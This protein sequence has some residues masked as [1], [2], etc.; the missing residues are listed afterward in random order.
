MSTDRRIPVAVAGATGSVGQRFVSLLE[1]HPWFRLVEVVASERSAGRPY[2]D[3]VRWAQAGPVPVEAGRLVVRGPEER[4]EAPIVF[5]ALDSSVAGPA[6]EALARAGHSV[7]SNARNHRMDPD[8]PLLVPEVNPDHLELLRRQSWSGRLITNPNCSTIGLVL[9][10]K[11]L[12]DAF[13]IEEVRVVTLQAIS[14]AG[15]PGVPSMEILDNVIPFISGEEEKLETEPLKILGALR[16]GA[17][18]EPADLRILAQCNRVPVLDGHTEC[19][20]VRFRGTATEEAIRRA[21]SGFRPEPQQRGLPSAPDSP[22]VFLEGPA[23]QPRLHRDLGGGMAASVGRLRECAGG[24]F[25]F[26][27]LSHNTLR[28]AAGGALLCGELALD[29]GDLP[30]IARP[31]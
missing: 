16:E 2:A 7:I 18:V 30:G 11:P 27:V 25:A 17:A 26:V 28:G 3:A 1:H 20:W 10:L 29:R 24:E 19:V 13:G 6:E 4:L 23:P 15:I 22:V 9:A 12:H 8:V 5:S 14:G 31:A 21:W